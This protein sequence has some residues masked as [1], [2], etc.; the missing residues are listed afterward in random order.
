MKFYFVGTAVPGGPCTALDIAKRTV[1]EA[2]PY[3]PFRFY[4]MYARSWYGAESVP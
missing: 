4:E 2:G 3:I 1:R